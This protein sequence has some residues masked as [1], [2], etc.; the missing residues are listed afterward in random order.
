[1]LS[2]GLSLGLY[3]ALEWEATVQTV[4]FRSDDTRE[5]IA[6]FRG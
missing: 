3:E 2:G 6:A 5:G 4:N 1:M